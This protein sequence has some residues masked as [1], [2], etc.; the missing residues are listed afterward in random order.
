MWEWIEIIDINMMLIY[1]VQPLSLFNFVDIPALYSNSVWSKFSGTFWSETNPKLK[2]LKYNLYYYVF[3]QQF[4]DFGKML[5]S[6]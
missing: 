5:F 4:S 1:N 2:W 6:H 3:K